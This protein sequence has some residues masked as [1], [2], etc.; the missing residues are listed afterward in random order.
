MGVLRPA[1]PLALAV[2]ACGAATVRGRGCRKVTATK[3]LWL[4][5]APT[6]LVV[7][8]KRFS[9]L[10]GAKITRSIDFPVSKSPLLSAPLENRRSRRCD[11]ALSLISDIGHR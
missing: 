4:L 3:Q 7:H 8:L 10:L 1:C 2:P 11:R 9:G 6:V 5:E